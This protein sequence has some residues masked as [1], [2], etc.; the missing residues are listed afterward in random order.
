MAIRPLAQP[1]AARPV[2]DV[3]AAEP[4]LVAESLLSHLP[5]GVLLFD[6]KRRL[7]HWNPRAAEMLGVDLGAILGVTDR[8]IYNLAD[9]VHEAA[10]PAWGH[11]WRAAISRFRERPRFLAERGPVGHLGL[12]VEMFPVDLPGK[13]KSWV[14]VILRDGTAEQQLATLAERERLAMDLHDGVMQ[15]LYALVLMLDA[16]ARTLESPSTEAHDAL[17]EAAVQIN[18]AILAI[19]EYVS[20]LRPMEMG[21]HGLRAGVAS[22]AAELH[23]STLVRSQVEVA[24]E[25]DSLLPP[26]SVTHLLYIAREAISNLIRHSGASAAALTLA[27]DRDRLVLTV[28]DDGCG[29]DPTRVGRRVGDGLKNMAERA[30]M[31]GGHLDVKSQAGKG[32]EVRLVLPRIDPGYVKTPLD[33]PEPASSS[34]P[35]DGSR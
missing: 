16:R 5:D 18:G 21:V 19:R 10:P 14:G 31:I 15:S 26:G 6:S 1:T 4:R 33:R 29:F 20:E 32:T 35:V 30:R 23:S 17:R 11:Q 13:R 7:R 3:G 25:V 9:A 12:I 8:Q 28:Q 27:V 2:T 22:L 34:G 24:D